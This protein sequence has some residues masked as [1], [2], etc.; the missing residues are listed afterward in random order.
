MFR[1]VFR[2]LILGS[3]SI[4]SISNAT[5]Q[6]LESASDIKLE[7][8]GTCDSPSHLGKLKDKFS[9][10]IPK[11]SIPPEQLQMAIEIFVVHKD[12]LGEFLKAYGLDKVKTEKGTTKMLEKEIEDT[13]SEDDDF[14]YS[15]DQIEEDLGKYKYGLVKSPTD[16]GIRSSIRNIVRFM[17]EKKDYP[18]SEIEDQI[19]ILGEYTATTDLYKELKK[20]IEEA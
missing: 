19:K 13:Q 11:G 14:E 18:K 2:I 1:K 9:L 12:S 6:L 8:I 10:E 7:Q 5:E 17:L 3:T 16:E 15:I 20:A 4:V